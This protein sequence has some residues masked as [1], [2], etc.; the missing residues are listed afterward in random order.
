MS[1]A[2][3]SSQQQQAEAQRQWDR[4]EWE[5]LQRLA[6]SLDYSRLVTVLRRHLAVSEGKRNDLFRPEAQV[7]DA[8]QVL[9]QQAYWQG[10]ADGLGFAIRFPE[11][12]AAATLESD[13][14]PI[15]QPTEGR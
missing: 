12:V 4:E 5:A 1:S 2:A 15:L 8:N 11:A 6:Q 9:R 10:Y 14:R 7:A 13:Q 3:I